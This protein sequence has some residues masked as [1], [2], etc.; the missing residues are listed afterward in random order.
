MSDVLK[1]GFPHVPS[2]RASP[3]SCDKTLMPGTIQFLGLH[4]IVPTSLCK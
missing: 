3:F 1:L 4:A 2:I